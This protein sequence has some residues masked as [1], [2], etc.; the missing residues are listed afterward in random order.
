MNFRSIKD[1]SFD[2]SKDVNVLVGVNGA[3]KSTILD[4]LAT[5][6]SW[7]V[8]RV[9]RE[10]A[11]GQRIDDSDIRFGEGYSSIQIFAEEKEMDFD[12][13][14]FKSALGV[15]NSK[16]SD[17][18]GATRLAEYFQN[19]IAEKST[20]PI[21]VYYPID[22]GVKSITPEVSGADSIGMLDIYKNALSGKANYQS[23]FEWFRLQDDVVNEKIGSREKWIFRNKSWIKKKTE[24]LLEDIETILIDNKVERE[25]S[26][27]L[28]N[29]IKKNDLIYKEPNYLFR[30]LRELLRKAEIKCLIDVSEVLL[31]ID[32]LLVMMTTYPRKDGLFDL[33]GPTFT[34]G[35]ILSRLKNF[36]HEEESKDI[37][38]QVIK[39]VWN[40]L[41]F[42]ILLGSWWVSDKGKSEIEEVLHKFNPNGSD[43]EEN[44]NKVV[45]NDLLGAINKI[46]SND[47]ERL[48]RETNNGG[49]EL[50][51]VTQAIEAF[52][53]NYRNLRVKR[54]PRPHML[55]EKEGITMSL[56][57]LSDGEKNLIALVG[58]IAR[59]LAIANSQNQNVNPLEGDGIVLIDEIDLHLH[60]S[61]QRK[62]IPKLTKIFPNCQ[63][64][65]STHSPQVLS[66]IQPEKIFLL[67]NENN[68][69]SY[70]KAIASYGKN[71]DR[72]LEDLL[73]VGARPEKP[74]KEI[75]QLFKLIQ[76]GEL[77]DA[78]I[79]LEKLIEEIGED[80]E[81]AKAEVLIKRKEIIGK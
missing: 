25:K 63:F 17:L 55:V 71:T 27:Y 61:W 19:R 54:L 40:S 64:I 26:K 4:A 2:L 57:Q 58:D 41:S 49:Q 47:A 5:S 9:K 75:H 12:W 48:D 62:M 24:L 51:Y 65:F 6:L 68:E 50:Q 67:K 36:F 32:V 79:K 18:E 70:G 31:G 3:G 1:Q 73:N 74:R 80:S 39:L 60:P 33:E 38:N 35:N 34:V 45:A 10:H 72:I 56:E 43:D 37:R 77:K 66:H 22:R 13:T 28:L 76:E 29:Q 53:P 15:T 8:N 23:F 81:L 52:I 78:K 20:L 69:L 30:E 46:I 11:S 42:A 21:V 14:L 7:F 44:L 16:K 59:R